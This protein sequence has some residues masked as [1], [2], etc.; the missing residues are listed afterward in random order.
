MDN[1]TV[2]GKRQQTASVLFYYFFLCV[3]GYELK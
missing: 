2:K 1:L 3:C